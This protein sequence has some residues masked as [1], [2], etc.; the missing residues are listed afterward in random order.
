MN[1]G[2]EVKKLRKSIPLTQIEFAK[3]VDVGLRFLR[4]L[5]QGKPSIRLDNLSKVLT[6]L[7]YHLIIVKNTAEYYKQ[8]NRFRYSISFNKQ[9]KDKIRKRDGYKC[10]ICGISQKFYKKKYNK[11]LSVHHI[12]YDKQNCK[13]DNLI[14]LCQSCHAKT[15]KHPELWTD[16]F[17]KMLKSYIP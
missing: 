9:L 17:R 5:E 8:E 13:E 2:K 16:F 12:D 6:F 3:R 1:I 4:E 15:K 7:G 10:C 14:S 11:H